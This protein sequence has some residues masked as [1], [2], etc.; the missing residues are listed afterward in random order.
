[1]RHSS[2][3]IQALGLFATLQTT[4]SDVHPFCDQI[5]QNSN[6]A[7]AKG[8]RGWAGRKDAPGTWR[9]TRRARSSPRLS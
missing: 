7:V 4:A 5:L 1:M 2:R 3:A 9:R 6:D 8:A